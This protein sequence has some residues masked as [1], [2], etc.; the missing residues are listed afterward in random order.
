MECFSD[1]EAKA[2]RSPVIIV[3]IRRRIF[4]KGLPEV[5]SLHLRVRLTGVRLSD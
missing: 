4:P 2:L 5:G 3:S 1:E